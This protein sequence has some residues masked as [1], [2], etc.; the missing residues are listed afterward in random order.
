[1]QIIQ[2]IREK[3]AA[4][5]IIVIAIS[6][7]GFILMDSNPGSNTSLFGG[8]STNVGKVNGKSIDLNDFNKRVEQE[9]NKQDRKSV[10]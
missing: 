3:G 7:I 2:S 8:N 1:M 6:L 9:S 5:I 4:I 10:V